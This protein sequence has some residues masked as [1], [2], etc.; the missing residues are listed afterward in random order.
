MKVGYKQLLAEANASIESISVAEAAALRDDP[1]SLFVDIRDVRELSRDGM[2]PNALHAPR[3]MLEFWVDPESPYHKPVFASGKRF[4]FYCASG[5]R[6]ALAAF[7]MQ[8]MGLEPVCHIEGGFTAWRDAK[9]P[10]SSLDK[11]PARSDSAK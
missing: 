10:V 11:P 4:I 1:G 2:I 6:S 3:G 8:R 9:L 5:W 7:A